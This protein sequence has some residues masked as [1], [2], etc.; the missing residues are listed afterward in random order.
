MMRSFVLAALAFCLVPSAQAQMQSRP[1]LTEPYADFDFWLGTWDVYTGDRKVG[2]NVI[3][4][5]EE[6]CLVLETWTAEGGA[7]GQSYNYFDPAQGVWRQVW[8]SNGLLID[9]EGGLD[10]TGS[11]VLEGTM[12]THNDA[13]TTPF[14]GRWTPMD[15]GTVQQT[16]WTYNA[17]TDA[18]DVWFDANYRRAT[19]QQ[20]PA[21]PAQ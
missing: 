15:D 7:T 1:C 9:Y 18:W 3:T 12:T 10:E 17:E 5:E 11:M 14:R 8:L 2:R 16:F 6:G 21:A 4:R 20:E 13:A 19:Q